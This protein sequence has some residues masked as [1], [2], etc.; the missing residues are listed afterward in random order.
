MNRYLL[1]IILNL[2]LVVAGLLDALI[3]YKMRKISLLKWLGTTVIWVVILVGLIGTEPAM[4]WLHEHHKIHRSTMS[5]FDVLEITGIIYI[6]FM[7]NRSRIK[8]DNLG[9]RLQ[10]LHQELSIK[11]SDEERR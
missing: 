3:A 4:A 7:A 5:L 2:P 10:D 6:L 1:L 9:R 8:V 11:L